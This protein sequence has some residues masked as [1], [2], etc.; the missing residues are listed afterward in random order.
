MPGV[1]GIVHERPPGIADTLS[2]LPG[3]Y[4]AYTVYFFTPASGT[5]RSG[6][7]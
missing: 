2:G 1:A 3:V 5:C 4:A 7:S 6:L